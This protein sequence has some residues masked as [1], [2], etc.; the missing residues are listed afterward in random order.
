MAV[1]EVLSSQLHKHLIKNSKFYLLF[2]VVVTEYL[3]N[4]LIKISGIKFSNS[5]HFNG[6]CCSQFCSI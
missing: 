3:A 5:F 6:E 1:T 2:I 4:L